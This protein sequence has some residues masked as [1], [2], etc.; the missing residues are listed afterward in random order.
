MGFVYKI[1]RM[2]F[3]RL[4]WCC[5]WMFGLGLD[6]D[7]QD[8]WCCEGLTGAASGGCWLMRLVYRIDRMGV[9]D[10]WNIFDKKKCLFEVNIIK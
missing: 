4:V 6:W 7:L 5:K 9:F 3:G 8:F 2:G 1:D 10:N